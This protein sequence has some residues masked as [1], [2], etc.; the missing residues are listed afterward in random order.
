MILQP[1]GE[2]AVQGSFPDL[3]ATN[4]LKEAEVKKKSKREDEPDNMRDAHPSSEARLASFKAQD[5][6]NAHEE[7]VPDKDVLAFYMKSMGFWHG[8]LF[9]ALGVFCVGLWK[10]SGTCHF[11]IHYDD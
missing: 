3:I 8:V 6:K 7:V 4:M 5:D 11:Q 10:V 1:E 2:G 9:M